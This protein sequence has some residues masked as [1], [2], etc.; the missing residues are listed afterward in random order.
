MIRLSIIV[1]FYNVEKYIEECIRSLYDQDIP[2]EEYEVICVDDC[3][4]DGSKTIVERL[5]KEYS[6]LRLLAH[7]E[8]KRQ[9]GAR[10]TGLREAKGKYVWF[11]DSDD[12][13]IPNCFKEMLGKAED[14]DLDF[15]RISSVGRDGDSSR[16]LYGPCTGSQYV[17]DA[18]IKEHPD[19]R[20][21][22]VCMGI[23]RRALLIDNDIWFA[24]KLQYEDDDYAYM[25]YAYAKRMMAIPLPAYV[26]RYREDST[27]Q[28]ALSLQTISYMVAQIKRI[29]EKLKI[30]QTIDSRWRNLAKRYVEWIC[31][32]QILASIKTLPKADKSMFYQEQMGSIDGLKQLV[33]WHVWLAMRCKWFYKTIWL[34]RYYKR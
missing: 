4:P 12:T 23:I 16:I 25:F 34:K 26:I 15:L 1:P 32:E 22:S 14:E 3:S 9:G 10:N 33:P 29:I 7:T 24:E 6:M 8:N 27:T 5:Q 13:I 20:C 18:P 21:C 28:G 19:Q 30:L 17:F 31:R 2:Q 11:V